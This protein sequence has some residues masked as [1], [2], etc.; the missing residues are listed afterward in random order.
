MRKNNFKRLSKA[1]WSIPILAALYLIAKKMRHGGFSIDIPSTLI[2]A[3]LGMGVI[4]AL[5][6]LMT[7]KE[8]NNDTTNENV[9]KENKSSDDEPEVES[10]D[11]NYYKDWKEGVAFD[12]V[13]IGKQIWMAQDFEEGGSKHPG[14]DAN[15]VLPDGWRLPDR[16]DFESLEKYLKNQFSSD[17]DIAHFLEKNWYRKELPD[18]TCPNCGG[19]G[20]VESPAGGVVECAECG[21]SGTLYDESVNELFWTSEVQNDGSIVCACLQKR[22]FG[23]CSVSSDS[24]VHLRLIKQN[25]DNPFFKAGEFFGKHF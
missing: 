16:E 1:G 9:D 13:A 11:T 14:L 22:K 19:S 3:I 24:I 4:V 7:R 25:E 10:V 6:W 17:I 20:A 2:W 21:G 12:T 18:D 23:F 8:V 5:A 15:M